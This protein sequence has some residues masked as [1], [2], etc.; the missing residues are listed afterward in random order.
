MFILFPHI[1]LRESVMANLDERSLLCQCLAAVSMADDELDGREIAAQISI[2]EQMTGVAPTA[3][4]IVAASIEMGDWDDFIDELP[5]LSADFSEEF[6]HQV[7]KACILIG[8][9][10][11]AMSIAESI[12]IS[13]LSAALGVTADQL[14]QHLKT[15]R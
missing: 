8:R 13:Y 12:R 4:E 6:R 15:I 5:D 7:L 2:I 9:A 3:D 14:E 10:D 11:D 1:L